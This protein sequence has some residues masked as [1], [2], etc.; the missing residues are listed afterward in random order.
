MALIFKS[1]K[2]DRRSEVKSKFSATFHLIL[3]SFLLV[4]F[5]RCCRFVLVVSVVS[6]VSFRSFRF[7]ILDFNICLCIFRLVFQICLSFT[8]NAGGLSVW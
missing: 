6:L 7:A 2:C 1:L 4:R 3:Y 8:A 5:G